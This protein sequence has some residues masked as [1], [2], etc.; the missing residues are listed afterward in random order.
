MFLVMTLKLSLPG[1]AKKRPKT[2]SGVAAIA[3][4]MKKH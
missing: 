3:K 4:L 2:E 1:G